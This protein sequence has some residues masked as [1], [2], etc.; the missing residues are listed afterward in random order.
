MF[1]YL[2]MFK[3]DYTLIPYPVIETLSMRPQDGLCSMSNTDK[4]IVV[5]CLKLNRNLISIS[6]L[7]QF[8]CYTMDIFLT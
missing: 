5:K 8:P 6:S 4:G 1:K 3:T 2:H 7:D